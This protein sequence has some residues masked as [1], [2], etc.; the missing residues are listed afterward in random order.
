MKGSQSANLCSRGK[1][2]WHSPDIWPDHQFGNDFVSISKSDA[3][4]PSVYW[5]CVKRLSFP[6]NLHP[7]ICKASNA[8]Q[9]PFKSFS[10]MAF[11]TRSPFF[12]CGW[13]S[14]TVFIT[15]IG[16]SSAMIA[17]AF[18]FKLKTFWTLL[19]SIFLNNPSIRTWIANYW[20]LIVWNG[21]DLNKDN[22]SV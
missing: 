17:P 22:N 21:G 1:L 18:D 15:C 8:N 5:S 7:T 2:N 10:F 12:V 19:R 20:N 16:S 3:L 9:N 11:G 6:V 13:P 14:P 4:S